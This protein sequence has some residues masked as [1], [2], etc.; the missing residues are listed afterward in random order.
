[1][2]PTVSAFCFFFH[3]L[4]ADNT[5]CI[6]RLKLKRWYNEL[7]ISPSSNF[8]KVWKTVM[9]CTSLIFF[10][11]HTGITAFNLSFHNNGYG[12]N[13]VLTIIYALWYLYDLVLVFDILI[14]V[15]TATDKNE[16]GMTIEL[17]LHSLSRI[18]FVS[19]FVS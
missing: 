10:I 3:P 1:M 5:R 7:V 9:F 2:F 4:P 19:S 6:S 18:H 8:Y 12:S 13:T 17:F 11:V 15:R 14:D 16:G